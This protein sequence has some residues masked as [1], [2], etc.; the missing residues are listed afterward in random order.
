MRQFIFSPS[1][2][3]GLSLTCPAFEANW[4]V[5]TAASYLNPGGSMA[6]AFPALRGA[7][8][9]N[10]AGVIARPRPWWLEWHFGLLLALTGC[11][12]GIRVA[13]LSVRGEESR[14]GRIAW[15]MWQNGDWIVPRIQGEPVFF[16]PPLQNWLIALVGGYRGE[17]D[18]A[19]LRIPSVVA[20]L[21]S[22]SVIYGYARSFLSRFGAFTC[23]LALASLGQVLELG[24]LGET[25]A[26]FMLFLSSS[27]FV[28]KWGDNKRVS[29]FITW[30]VS[31]ALAALATLTKGPQAPL[32]FV[33]SVSIYC[34]LTRRWRDLFSIAHLTGILTGLFVVGLWQVPYTLRMGV[35][36]SIKLY[37]HDVGPRFYELSIKSVAAHLITY[38]A[39]LLG[40]SLLPWSVWFVLLLSPRIRRH[41]RAWRDDALYLGICL[42]V[43]FP[44]VWLAPLASLRYYMPLFPCIACLVGIVVEGFVSLEER[45]GWAA[46][47]CWY[48]RVLAIAIAGA[49]LGILGISWADPSSVFAQPLGFAVVYLL[50]CGAAAAIV[51]RFSAQ[52]TPAALTLTFTLVACFLGLSQS[53]VVVNIR[54]ESSEDARQAI[55]LLK[56]KVPQGESLVSLGPAH[57]LFLYHLAQNVR[58][59]PLDAQEPDA[60]GNGGYFCMWVKG[61]DVVSLCFPWKLIATISCDRNHSADPTEIM[62]VGRRDQTVLARGTVPEAVRF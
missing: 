61:T 18:A 4:F 23:G 56:D 11:F 20:I 17:F 33:G 60:W 10:Q 2:K 53:S 39:E 9:E 12:F 31:Y 47:M 27:L 40:G 51:W 22:V 32:Y 24:R 36:D 46:L 26:L 42:A 55:R 3:C 62:I 38:P 5:I 8:E 35:S 16:R 50:L 19:A 44:S 34:L 49:G 29:P 48:Q 54:R 7:P 30:S 28:W 14:R 15:E 41:L 57:H 1:R 25:D 59:L 37:F 52:M 43:T 13:D 6:S 21:L 45:G 58:M